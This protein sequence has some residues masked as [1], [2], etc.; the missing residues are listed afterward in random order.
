MLLLFAHRPALRYRRDRGA[1]FPD[2]LALPWVVGRFSAAFLRNS[3]LSGQWT[4]VTTP[5]F[6]ASV[7]L[8]TPCSLNLVQW[9]GMPYLETCACITSILDWPVNFVGNRAFCGRLQSL[10]ALPEANR[11]VIS[12]S[13]IGQLCRINGV[14]AGDR[15]LAVFALPGLA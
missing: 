5:L 4:A 2:H 15:T 7:G 6:R 1:R 3:R 14:T 9:L 10:S 12:R 8:R 13:L 11:L